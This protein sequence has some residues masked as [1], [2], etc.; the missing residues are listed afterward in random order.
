MPDEVK[1]RIRESALNFRY[2][3]DENGAD[4]MCFWSENHA[5]TFYCCQYMAGELYPDDVFLR[6]GR[7]GREQKEVATRRIKEWL[8]VIE[9]E[10]FEEF[11]AG[12]YLAVTAA[13]L[14]FVYDFCT[15][16]LAERAA[17]IMDYIANEAAIQC[18]R[19]IHVAPMGRIYRSSMRPY[20]SSLQCLLH[21]FSDDNVFFCYAKLVLFG[22]SKY[23][24]PDVTDI[25]T[26]DVDVVFNSG[27]AEIH[28]KKTHDYMLTSVASPRHTDYPSVENE[29]TEYFRTK[30]MN[31]SFHGTSLFTPGGYGYQQHLWY[32]AISD[33]F[34]TF[35]N[36]PGTERDFCGMRPGYWFGN[37]IFPALRQEGKYL[38]LYPN[39]RNVSNRPHRCGVFHFPIL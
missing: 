1:A 39:Q 33:E 9:V 22:M 13:A 11:C 8:D 7:T 2:W 32:A 5:L 21:A 15:P 20:T 25:M 17:R 4:A 14:G 24:F 23:K 27:R 37:L 16:D 31:E 34:Y 26:R 10:R 6:S 36:L 29:D 30:I 18:F 19:G 28:T 3:M 35:V 38:P 12:G